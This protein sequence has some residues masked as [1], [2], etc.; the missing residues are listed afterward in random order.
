VKAV[1]EDPG[2]F[3]GEGLLHTVKMRPL[4]Y[5]GSDFYITVDPDTLKRVVPD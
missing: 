4:L 5:L 2:P 1:Q 3:A